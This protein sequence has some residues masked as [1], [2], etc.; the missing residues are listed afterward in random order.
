MIKEIMTQKE[1]WG[2]VHKEFRKEK[3]EMGN[4]LKGNLLAEKKSTVQNT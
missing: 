1:N 4:F 3:E 2:D